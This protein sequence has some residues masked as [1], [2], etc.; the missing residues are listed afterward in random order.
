MVIEEE[1]EEA[2][3]GDTPL[4]SSG[5]GSPRGKCGG[6]ECRREAGYGECERAGKYL[7]G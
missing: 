6:K 2:G 5:K 4:S 1:G 3:P 7:C